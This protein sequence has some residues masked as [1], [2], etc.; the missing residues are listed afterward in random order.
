MGKKALTDATLDTSGTGS[1]QEVWRVSGQG[2]RRARDKA[3]QPQRR[4]HPSSI[5][6]HACS[7]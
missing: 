4:G 6:K 2:H 5:G 7:S 1:D 3:G